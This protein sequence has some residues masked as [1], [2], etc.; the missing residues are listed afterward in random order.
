MPYY[1]HYSFDLWLT[2]IRSN[3]DY[4]IERTKIYHRDFNP[5]GKSVDEVAK[6][7]R[8]VDLMC[9]AVNERTGKNIDAEE[10]FLMVIS[11]INDNQLNLNELDTAQLYAEMEALVFNYLPTV[12][13]P[14]TIEVLDNLKQKSGATFS[15]L[16]NTG[17]IKGAT[18]K[19]VLAKLKMDKY[20]DFQLYSDEVGMSKPNLEFFNL[21]LQNIKQINNEKDIT[22]A[23]KV[24]AYLLKVWPITNAAKEVLFLTELEEIFELAQGQKLNSIHIDLFKR[25]SY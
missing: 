18:L 3:P 9:N 12:Y 24:C 10:M 5:S 20:F 21:M 2:L 7:F 19:K 6:A 17:F 8:T 14:V 22:L 4:K 13:E 16:S 1:Q 23:S 11:L 15:L 25:F